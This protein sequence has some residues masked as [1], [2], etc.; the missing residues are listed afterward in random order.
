MAF[1]VT[2]DLRRNFRI[3]ASQKHRS[4]D[5]ARV[6]TESVQKTSSFQRD[7]TR[8]DTQRLSRRI[9]Q[10]EDVVR[11]NAQ[12]SSTR[13]IQVTRSS[14]N[15]DDA[16]IKRVLLLHASFVHPFNGVCVH[17]GAI[18]VLVVHL[19]LSQRRSVPKV[20][21]PD[22][23]LNPTDHLPPIVLLLLLNGPTKRVR[24][25]KRLSQNTRLVHQ[26]LRNATD[27]HARPAETPRGPFL[28]RFH[29]VKAR[30]FRAVPRRL[31]RGR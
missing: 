21:G 20:Q 4:H 17:E 14:T 26:L 13:G 30:D 7:V 22:V 5:D 11:S 31:L 6:V 28:A 25:G 15:R 2:D 19:L 24:I 29:K 10:R 16:L 27:V 1:H 12:F 23:I 8:S 3:E 9:L 18:F